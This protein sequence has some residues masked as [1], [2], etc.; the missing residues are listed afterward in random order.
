[1]QINTKELIVLVVA[2]FILLF[3]FYFF[4]YRKKDIV[5]TRQPGPS[6]FKV[7]ERPGINNLRHAEGPSMNQNVEFDINNLETDTGDSL[8][9]LDRLEYDGGISKFLT[10]HNAHLKTYG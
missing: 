7:G 1:M 4:F 3:L 10:S 6:Q 5:A 2:M 9:A 8:E